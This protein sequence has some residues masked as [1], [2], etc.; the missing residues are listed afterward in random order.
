MAQSERRLVPDEGVRGA[1]HGK[2]RLDELDA[3]RVARHLVMFE[4]DEKV[5][6]DLVA[7]ARLTIP[8]LAPA[9]EAIKVQRH[10]PIC[11]M[12]LARKS[13]FDPASP[14]GEGFIAILPLTKLGLQ[15][16][17]LGQFDASCPDVRLIAKPNERPAGIYMWGVYGPGPLA[18]GM[19]LFMEKMSSPQFA[20]VNLYSR[21]NTEVGVRFNQVLGFQRGTSVGGIEAP[22]VWIFSRKREVPL[23]DSYVRGAAKTEIGISVA[24]TLEDFMRIAAVRN[25]VYIG[26]QECPYE[27][28]YDG[29]DLSATHLIAYMGDEPVGCL[30]VRFFAEFAKFER[31]AIRK[32]FRKSRAA[33]LLA[34]AGLKL[35]RKKGYRRAYAH[36]QARLV[37]FWKHFGFSPLEGSKPFVFSD[38]DYVEIVAD[39]E[40]DI[41]AIRLGGD[42]YVII[43]PE[44]RWHRSGI[45]DRSAVRDA[46]NPSVTK[47]T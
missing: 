44:G 1:Q 36:S 17:V 11:V 5:L 43:R 13:K 29:N 34:Q 33:I 24:R 37:G 38:F 45:L 10:N 18:A 32:E 46:T 3:A 14:V 22:N 42:P 30:R 47:K 31:M 12:A 40:P 2:H 15:S 39:L 16:L 7:K 35:A 6:D 23:Y 26:E 25:A 19:A 21:P 41:D 28:E 27:E 4:P 8:G 9:S 20:G